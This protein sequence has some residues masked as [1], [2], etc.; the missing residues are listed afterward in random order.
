MGLMRWGMNFEPNL[1]D[2]LTDFKVELEQLERAAWEWKF[3]NFW[4]YLFVV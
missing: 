3:A 1:T 4:F 2:Q